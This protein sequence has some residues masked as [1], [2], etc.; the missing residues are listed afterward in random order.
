M[1]Q[2][3]AETVTLPCA[4]LLSMLELLQMHIM[5]GTHLSRPHHSSTCLEHTCK[6]S[7]PLKLAGD[8]PVTTHK[9]THTHAALLL[10]H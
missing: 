7:A 5:T 2:K 8:M 3:K 10:A 9:N 4:A 1:R 6:C